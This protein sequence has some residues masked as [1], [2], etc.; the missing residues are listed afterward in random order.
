MAALRAPKVPPGRLGPSATVD[1]VVAHYRG[2]LA[3]SLPKSARKNGPA[4]VF[5][6]GAKGSAIVV[7]YEAAARVIKTGLRAEVVQ[8][9][10]SAIPSV[11]R[12]AILRHIGIDKGTLRRRVNANKSLD[13]AQTEGA[14]RAMELTVLAAETFGTTT[15]AGTWLSRPHALLGGERPIDFASNHYGLAKVRSMLSAIRFGGVV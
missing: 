13:R 10:V 5:R 15:K 6:R 14:L 2:A 11:E 4:D 9:I 7:S 12:A 3:A 1:K 8:R